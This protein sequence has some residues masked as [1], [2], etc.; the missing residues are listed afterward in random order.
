M[1]TQNQK[2]KLETENSFSG[3]AGCGGSGSQLCAR[4]R[5][6]EPKATLPGLPSPQCAPYPHLLG[7]EAGGWNPAD[8]AIRAQHRQFGLSRGSLSKTC[9]EV[10]SSSAAA[11]VRPFKTRSLLILVPRPLW[12]P[13][14]KPPEP[15][16]SLLS[17]SP[18]G[19]CSTSTGP[20][21]SPANR[22]A[23]KEPHPPP[24]AP[25][26]LPRPPPPALLLWI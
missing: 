10:K 20:R 13:P 24:P 11:S 7:S 19:H 9:S 17:K 22:V 14:T 1:D 8:S 18:S 6:V 4:V 21:A 12:S 25:C 2:P 5:R 26:A 15:A 16:C 23:L 3:H